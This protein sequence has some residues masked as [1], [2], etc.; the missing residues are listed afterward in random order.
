MA[1]SICPNRTVASDL[2]RMVYFS[3]FLTFYILSTSRAA[4][5]VQ[6]NPQDT[7]RR[8]GAPHYDR[9]YDAEP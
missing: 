8:I 7:G 4:Y 3:F 9:L 2:E 6:N 1:L 5:T